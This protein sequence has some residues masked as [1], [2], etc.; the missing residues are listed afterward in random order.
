MDS[1]N[2]LPIKYPTELHQKA[3]EEITDFFSRI[4]ETSAVL[5]TCSCAR[6]KAVKDSCL[7]IAVLH[8]PSATENRL[9]ETKEAWNK[10]HLTNKIYEELR[11]IGKYS[12]IDLEFINGD[13][14]EGYH[15]W[16]S[17]PDEFELEIGNFIA[18]SIPLYTN[19]NY[20]EDLRSKWLPYYNEE[21][22]LKRLAMVKQYCLNNLHHIPGYVE[23]RLYFQ[24]FNRLYHALGEFLQA[25]FITEKIYPISYDKWIKDQLCDLL[26]LP[27]LYNV[28]VKLME[29]SKFEGNEHTLKAEVLEN[30]LKCYCKS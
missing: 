20:F 19:G 24:C 6:G 2:K 23:R 17:G 14:K 4:E 10:E 8:D 9:T 22:R 27:D 5:L 26:H 29:F 18:Y 1:S 13:F 16:T 25:L 12:Q 15:G 3:A 11:K 7:D 30:L 21:M 28:F